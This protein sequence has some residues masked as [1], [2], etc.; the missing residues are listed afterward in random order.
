MEDE[1]Q[2]GDCVETQVG[3]G[4]MEEKVFYLIR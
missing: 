2:D 1:I 4:F 3:K